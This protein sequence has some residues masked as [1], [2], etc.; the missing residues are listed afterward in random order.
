MVIIVIAPSHRDFSLIVDPYVNQ[1]IQ[2]QA[3]TSVITSAHGS[4]CWWLRKPC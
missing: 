2:A 4:S 3:A 1:F